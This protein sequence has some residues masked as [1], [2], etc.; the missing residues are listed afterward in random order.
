VKPYLSICAIYRWEGPYLREWVA[1]HRTVGVERFFLY[2]NNSDDDHLEA[3]APYVDEGTVE[4]QHWPRYPNGQYPA[5]AHCLTEHAQDS[6]WIAFLDVDEFLFSPIGLPLPEILARYERW[7]GIGVTRVTFGTSGH[8]RR[9]AGLVLE[10]YTRRLEHPGT[11]NSVKSV[12]D[13][14]RT[15]HPLNPHVFAYTEGE[16]VDEQE[17]PLEGAF[18]PTRSSAEL[19]INH[20]FTKSDQEMVLKMSRPDASGQVRKVA[21]ANPPGKGIRDDRRVGVPD[22]T[23]LRYLPALHAE[24]DRVAAG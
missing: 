14:A 18:S 13:P 5:Y 15:L 19:R 9:P 22:D 7:P 10:S 1:F 8:E 4:L 16:A 2:D 17:Q 12:V 21:D 3:L 6:R 11:G 23:I 20:Y 24:L